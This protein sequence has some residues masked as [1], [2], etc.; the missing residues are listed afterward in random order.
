MAQDELRFG[1]VGLGMGRHHCKAVDAARGCRLTAVC[2]IDAERLAPVAEEYRATAHTSYDDMLADRE[3]D[4]VCIAT[5]SGMHADMGLQAIAAGKH[6]FVEKPV[7]VDIDKIKR[8]AEAARRSGLKAGAVFQSRTDPLNKRIKAAVE[9]GRLGRMV[10]VHAMLPW[11]RADSYFQGPHGS[12]KGTWAMDGG[13][14]LM[15]QGVHTVDLIQWFAGRVSSV[16]GAFDVYAH[17]IEAEDKT[18]A[19][20]RFANG[21]LGTLMTTTAAIGGAPQDILLHGDQGTI[22]KTSELRIWKLLDDEQ[23]QEE[24]ELMGYYGPKDRRPEGETV[25]TDPTAVGST[26]HQFQIEDLA[27]AVREG[28]KPF[29]AVEDALHAVE[30]VNAIYESGRTGQEVSIPG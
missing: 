16:F 13:G 21:A 7:D 8:L 12:W 6:I 2:D 20:L 25:A 9:Q 17:D 18:V 14:S 15:N 23:G 22:Q 29:I 30:I 5:P 28:G 11:Y 24:N 4:A 10:G 1:V 3:V 26:G 19:I 27:R